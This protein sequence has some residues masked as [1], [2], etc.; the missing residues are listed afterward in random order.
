MCLHAQ[1]RCPRAFLRQ[2]RT[3][4]RRARLLARVLPVSLLLAATSLLSGVDVGRLA[5]FESPLPLEPLGP[6]SAAVLLVL[7]LG[8]AVARPRLL[9]PSRAPSLDL[10]R[11]P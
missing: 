3:R 9:A 10:P 7:L 8:T 4:R 11:D 6:G 5:S 2:E 1:R